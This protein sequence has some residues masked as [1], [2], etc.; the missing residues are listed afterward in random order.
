MK[1]VVA[2]YRDGRIVKGVTNDFLPTKDRFHLLPAGSQPGAIPVEVL[3][4]NLKAVFFVFDLKGSPEHKKSNA[5][6]RPV[7]GRKIR[8]VF[9][10]GE[11]MTGT[12]NGYNPGRPGF[13]LF[14]ADIASN[15]ERCFVVSGAAKEITFL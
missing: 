12:T 7:P 14:P 13:V 10:D 15:N 9:A 3:I 6:E 8:V 4:S 11:V 1:P 5:F 2:H